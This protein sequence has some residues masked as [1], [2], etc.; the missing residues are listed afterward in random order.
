MILRI[1]ST[2][3]RFYDGVIYR[4]VKR[5]LYDKRLFYIYVGSIYC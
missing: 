1:Y 3:N 2:A 5:I 4:L